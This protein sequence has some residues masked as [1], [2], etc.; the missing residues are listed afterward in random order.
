M[1]F[2]DF[3]WVVTLSGSRCR[4]YLTVR[5]DSLINQLRFS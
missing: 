3:G 5:F 4:K 1:N 2:Y